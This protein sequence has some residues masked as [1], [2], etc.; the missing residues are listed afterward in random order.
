MKRWPFTKYV[1]CGNDFLLFDNRCQEFPTFPVLIQH[2]CH[3]QKGIGADGLL[4]WENSIKAD[5]RLRI[6]NCDGS[7]AEMCG[8]GL[9]CFVKWLT[10]LGFKNHPYHIEIAQNVWTAM[11]TKQVV[12]IEMKS[13][14]HIQWDISLHFEDQLL[15]VH[16]LNTGVPHAVLFVEDIEHLNLAKLGPYLRYH[17]LWKP[18][19]TNVTVTQVVNSK[20]IKIRTYERGVEGETLACGTG[21]TAAALAAAYQ[22]GL[23]SPLN[24]ETR[25]GEELKIEFLFAQQKFFSITLTGSAECIFL[26]EVE[27]PD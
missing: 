14:S 2:L 27:L 22:E 20:K 8:N 21:A 19:G 1:G 26:G 10:N 4:L 18:Y 6:F 7:E 13:P 23:L 12:C 15:R 24:V 5:F 9:R 16:Y 17:P 3:R 25:S 11:Q